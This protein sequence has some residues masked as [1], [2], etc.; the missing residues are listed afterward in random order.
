MTPWTVAHP[1]PL[2]MEYSRQEYWGGLP[3]PP[4]GLP[5]PGMEPVSPV[6]PALQVDSL[7]LSRQG[8][9]KP[10]IVPRTRLLVSFLFFC[11]CSFHFLPLSF[12][13]CCS[14]LC[15]L[16]FVNIVSGIRL[17]LNLNLN[18]YLMCCFS[19]SFM[20]CVSFL[21]H[22]PTGKGKWERWSLSCLLEEERG[23]VENKWASPTPRLRAFIRYTN[24]II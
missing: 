24:C 17:L 9:P 5:N 11:F 15:V 19:L 10:S 1:V 13:H 12:C 22:Q 7:K 14:L 18:K 4:R 16:I 21:P 23:V 2:S 8:S 20:N 6:C 3:F